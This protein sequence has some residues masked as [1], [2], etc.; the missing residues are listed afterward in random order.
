MIATGTAPD[1]VE[2]EPGI[3]TS[4]VRFIEAEVFEDLAPYVERDGVDLSQYFESVLESYRYNGTLPVLPKKMGVPLVIY[5]KDFFDRAGVPYPDPEWT[6][7]DLADT[8]RR[9][10]RDLNGDG[11]MDEWAFANGVFDGWH[12]PLLNGWTWTSPD[13]TRVPTSD[14][15]FYEAL[16]FRYDINNNHQFVAPPDVKSASGIPGYMFFT[17]GRA[18]MQEGDRWYVSY[19]RPVIQ[20]SFDW[21]ATWIPIPEGGTRVYQLTSE[22]WGIPKQSQAKEAAWTFIKWASGPDGAMT[23]AANGG[24]IPTVKSLAYSPEFL[25]IGPPSP[26]GNR[27]WVEAIN[28]AK[29]Y[30]AS[31][32][33]AEIFS[34][35]GQ[36]LGPAHRGETSY[37][38]AAEAAEPIVS[39]FLAQ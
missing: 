39:L 12:A 22:A 31:S 8:A 19:F 7:D 16:E 32:T 34:R 28:Y 21:D 3:T 6:W 17:T 9:L 29:P 4:Y 1:I 25:E 23:W 26:E 5:N 30:P 13:G 18:A 35:L 11:D 36:L 37:R 24:A 33:W 20:D 15:R 38:A 14:P 27:L 10:T 2:I